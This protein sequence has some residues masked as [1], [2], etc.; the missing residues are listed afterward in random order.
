[1]AEIAALRTSFVL[2]LVFLADAENRRGDRAARRATVT[3]VRETVDDEPVTPYAMRLVDQ[4]QT[5]IGQIAAR[6]ARRSG[7]LAEEL[8]DREL[9]ILRLLPGSATQPGRSA[10]R[11]SC[12]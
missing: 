1:M 11:C 6:S 7:V 2:A 5:R 8:T 4:A 9:S 3:R 10:G 12:R